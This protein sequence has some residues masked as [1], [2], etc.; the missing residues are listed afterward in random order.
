IRGEATVRA[1]PDLHMGQTPQV[2]IA[3]VAERIMR[4]VRTWESHESL[5]A[6]PDILTN[7]VLMNR[8]QYHR[9]GLELIDFRFT[10][11]EAGRQAMS[12]P[13]KNIR[14]ADILD[15]ANRS[16]IWRP[17]LSASV[18]ERKVRQAIRKQQHD[19]LPDADVVTLL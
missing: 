4:T 3:L 16:G 18:R 17:P 19:S 1:R 12:R 13:P 15:D 14:M 5:L 9:A 8:D 11:F 2:L 10:Q 7:A 6:T